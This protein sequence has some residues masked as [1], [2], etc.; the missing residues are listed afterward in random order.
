MA[1]EEIANNG[2]A[3]A[4]RIDNIKESAKGNFV[5]SGC[6][7]S[8][9]TPAT[10]AVNIASGTIRIGRSNVVVSSTSKTVN[11]SHATLDRYDI[12]SVG[13]DAVVDY[14]AGTAATNPYPPD[15]AADHILLAVI[16]VEKA[17]TTVDA[18]DVADSRIIGESSTITLMHSGTGSTTST[19]EIVL[20]SYTFTAGEFTANEYVLVELDLAHQGGANNS[21]ITL[22]VNTLDLSTQGNFGSMAYGRFIAY[23]LL[24][25]N[26]QAGIEGLFSKGANWEDL[27]TA[28]GTMSANWITTA[29]TISL[30]GYTTSPQTYYWR[31]KVYRMRH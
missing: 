20:D 27:R 14:T 17:S 3:F 30:R 9:Q 10:M 29:W 1:G 7:V 13:S 16:F 24:Y 31:W 18:A 25:N 26:A 22:R 2:Y 15:L 6:A 12:I 23:Q 4:C 28:G 21:F 19:T 11:A 8:A 5:V